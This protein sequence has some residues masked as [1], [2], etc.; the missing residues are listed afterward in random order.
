MEAIG[1]WSHV[2]GTYTC[3]C[4]SGAKPRSKAPSFHTPHVI[5]CKNQDLMLEPAVCIAD[6]KI[7]EI[8]PIAKRQP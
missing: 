7:V 1:L 2:D 3:M 5:R 6:L 8:E 4:Y